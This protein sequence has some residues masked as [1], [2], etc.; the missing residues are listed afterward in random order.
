MNNNRY[1]RSKSKILS[2]N[3]FDN[4]K[5]TNKNIFLINNINFYNYYGGLSYFPKKIIISYLC[6][7]ITLITNS[8]SKR[9]KRKNRFWK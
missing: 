5:E 6:I 9:K 8:N 3:S 2:F 7:Q 1:N 4:N